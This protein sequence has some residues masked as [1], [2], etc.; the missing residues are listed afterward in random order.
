[1]LHPHSGEASRR[2]R[3]EAWKLLLEKNKYD[4][5]RCVVGEMM[6]G[7]NKVTGRN[8]ATR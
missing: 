3:E 1:M 8:M 2:Y 6:P 5:M 4:I 7:R